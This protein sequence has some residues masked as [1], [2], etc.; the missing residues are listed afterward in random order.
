[1]KS[2][3]IKFVFAT[4]ALFFFYEAAAAI[5]SK[6]TSLALIFISCT[7]AGAAL[8]LTPSVLTVT[9]T[10]LPNITGKNRK[11]TSFLARLSVLCSLAA[12]AAY[13]AGH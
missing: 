5:T 6:K 10:K 8:Y 13:A 3:I 1:M 2:K 12:I 11:R 4:I 9:H 7:L